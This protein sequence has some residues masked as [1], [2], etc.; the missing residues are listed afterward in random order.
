MTNLEVAF[1]GAN[2]YNCSLEIQLLPT[3]NSNPL[4]LVIR[5]ILL[6]VYSATIFFIVP[7]LFVK[8]RRKIPNEPI[9]YLDTYV[10]ALD[11]S[12]NGDFAD[13]CVSG[14]QDN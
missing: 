10:K 13:N 12:E 9:V 4:F 3:K 8:G 2:K 5:N 7:R 1:L 6:S 14:L 11:F